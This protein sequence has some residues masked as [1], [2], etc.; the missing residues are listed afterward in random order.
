MSLLLSFMAA[1]AME[2][3]QFQ[4]GIPMVTVESGWNSGITT[5]AREVISDDA[6]WQKV[7]KKH[8]NVRPQPPAPDV[9]FRKE[10]I[11]A[12]FMGQRSSG[13][14]SIRVTRVER[15]DG[16]TY[17]YY[18][19]YNPP[20]GSFTTAAMSAPYHLVKVPRYTGPVYFIATTTN[21]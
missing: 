20:P 9:D 18:T 1:L 8:S 14:Y 19:N 10:M 16:A 4:P 21:K 15:R 7:Y 5:A 3:P 12:V 17:V 6:R 2:S 11:V 13:G